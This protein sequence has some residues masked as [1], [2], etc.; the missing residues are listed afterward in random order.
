MKSQPK[1]N[2][3]QS[4]PT[5]T[6]PWKVRECSIKNVIYMFS[7]PGH[8][9]L[10]TEGMGKV[11]LDRE[12]NMCS[13]MLS[14]LR[15]GQLCDPMDSSQPGSSVHGI[16]QAR[17]LENIAMPSS[18]GSSQARDRMLRSYLLHWQAGSLP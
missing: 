2:C 11:N 13:A 3:M 10:L 18:R 14:R 1:E 15:C 4:Q 16:L 12:N 8:M 9:G 7:A 5:V 6:V 17:I